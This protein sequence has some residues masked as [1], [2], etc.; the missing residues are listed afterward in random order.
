LRDCKWVSLTM[1]W[2]NTYNSC[3]DKSSVRLVL[4]IKLSI[5]EIRFKSILFRSINL[6]IFWINVESIAFSIVDKNK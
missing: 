2:G 6:S 5:C 4:L 1:L 3:F